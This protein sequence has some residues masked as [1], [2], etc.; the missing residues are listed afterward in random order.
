M[1]MK[2]SHKIYSWIDYNLS[3][4]ISLSLDDYTFKA[5][6]LDEFF[7]KTLQYLKNAI[8]ER[9]PGWILIG[10]WGE[11][12]STFAYNLCHK[13][14]DAFFFS[15]QLEDYNLN[16]INH[17]LAVYVPKPTKKSMLL[18]QT[19]TEGFPVPWDPVHLRKKDLLDVRESLLAS[20]FRKL[21]YLLLRKAL[22][23]SEFLE[24][25][26]IIQNIPRN[27]REVFFNKKLGTNDLMEFVDKVDKHPIYEWIKN[28]LTL[29]LH[30]KAR[31]P[32]SQELAS[33]VFSPD[34]QMFSE[35][36]T[37]LRSMYIQHQWNFDD[38]KV[39]CKLVGIHVFL[40]IDEMEDWSAVIRCNLDEEL[41]SMVR[42]NAIS[43][44][45]ILRTLFPKGIKKDKS[46][47]A[48]LKLFK[49]LKEFRL[50]RFD[51]AQLIQ[52]TKGVLQTSRFSNNSNIF[53]LTR[54]FV[55]SLAEK[56]SRGGRFNPRLFI[57]CLSE[58]LEKSLAIPR[59]KI[60]LDESILSEQWVRDIIADV[61][62][63]EAIKQKGIDSNRTLLLASASSEIA[64]HVLIRGVKDRQ[65][66]DELKISVAK[67]W[68]CRVPSD[69]DVLASVEDRFYR[70]RLQHIIES[71]K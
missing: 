48:Y 49:T 47:D 26:I 39:L 15:D 12:K 2:P 59:E 14:N 58:I 67:K 8:K 35:N 68:G 66:F 54:E 62:V 5:Y 36:F 50:P 53:P 24:G 11:G 56:T 1:E 6:G 71:L 13:V 45:L 34:T 33:L 3:G 32:A 37:S 27:L 31:F 61:L 20:G 25:S 65:S 43:V 55:F 10:T 16:D 64:D 22:C 44:M 41:L 29:W 21:S 9:H 19:I 38:F 28:F 42:E 51:T 18:E 30:V 70:R 52:L 40:V 46:F 17:I 23:D 57:K 60:E 7:D 69:F 63:Q 4:P